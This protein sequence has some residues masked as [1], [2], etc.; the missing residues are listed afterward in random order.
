M[1]SIRKSGKLLPRTKAWT[2]KDG[3]KLRRRVGNCWTFLK[4]GKNLAALTF[5]LSICV[6]GPWAAVT[7]FFKDRPQPQIVTATTGFAAGRDLYVQ[8]GSAIHFGL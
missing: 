1:A 8:G 7:F 6:G 5:V 4:D 2:S 3:W